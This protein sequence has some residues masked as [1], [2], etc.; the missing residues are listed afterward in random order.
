MVAGLDE[1]MEPGEEPV[2]TTFPSR[3]D[4]S[5]IR[6]YALATVLVIAIAAGYYLSRTGMI[7]FSIPMLWAFSALLVPLLVVAVNEVR[8]RFTVYCVTD[9]RVIVRTGI[10]NKDVLTASYSQITDVRLDK[11]FEERIFDVGT[12]HINTAGSDYAE[13]TLNG[14]KD[15]EWFESFVNE[16][17]GSSRRE[18]SGEAV[19]ERHNSSDVAG[20]FGK[21][22]LESRLGR[23][24]MQ[25]SKL[26]ERYEN[27]E[28]GES[29][30]R[31]QWYVLEGR[32]QEIV[33]QLEELERG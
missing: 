24:R 23:I 29:E 3:F 33:G 8:R 16:R 15:P 17:A 6:W 9:R 27:G 13:L 30:Y 12:L 20:S 11:D 31:E 10:L 18:G 25:K 14:L 5:Y 4:T 26:D 22:D 21:E 19:E 2:E 1:M 32:E 28:L 7:L